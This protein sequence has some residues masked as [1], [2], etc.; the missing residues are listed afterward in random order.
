M[1]DG[2]LIWN[3]RERLKGLEVKIFGNG[4]H[5]LDHKVQKN[6]DD[7]TK[8][9]EKLD[10]VKLSMVTTGV[11]DSHKKEENQRLDRLEDRIADRVEQKLKAH[12]KGW[13]KYL[14]PILTGIAAI[15]AVLFAN[16]GV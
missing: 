12:E 5:G 11:F 13:I 10:E 16:G 4:Q 7:I 3:D 8:L 14:G 6:C 15:L 1:S 9:D 2:S